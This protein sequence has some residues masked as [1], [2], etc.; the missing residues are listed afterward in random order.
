MR[1]IDFKALS[2]LRPSPRLFRPWSVIFE[3][4]L[5]N[6]QTDLT[7]ISYPWKLR[8]MDCKELSLLRLSLRLF[9]PWSVIAEELEILALSYLLA[10]Y[11]IHLEKATNQEKLRLMDCKELSSLKPLPRLFR[12]WSVIL[13]HLFL[14][15]NE[16]ILQNSYLP[17]K[18]RLIDCNALSL[19]RP[20]PIWSRPW[21]EILSQLF[22]SQQIYLTKVLTSQSWDWWIVRNWLFWDLH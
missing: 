7:K 11:Q 16:L 10:S 8:L 12:P 15:I 2:I 1:L 9:R 21:S 19:L 20:S 22:V 5:T 13:E 14:Q 18:L 4:L 17:W 6:Q 3:H